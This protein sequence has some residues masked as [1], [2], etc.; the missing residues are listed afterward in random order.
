MI[1]FQRLGHR[2]Q[3][4]ITFL[5]F[6]T[7]LLIRSRRHVA[8]TT[9]SIAFLSVLVE[10]KKRLVAPGL[11]LNFLKVDFVFNIMGYIAKHGVSFASACLTVHKYCSI[12]AIERTHDNFITAVLVNLVIVI[13]L[14]ETLIV[15]VHIAF[16]LGLSQIRPIIKT[17]F[18]RI[19]CH[20]LVQRIYPAFP[21]LRLV[22][23]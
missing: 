15:G 20:R 5:H 7:R 4:R 13:I 21:D 8:D 9:G 17:W 3:D 18:V 14:V 23:V 6:V 12:N 19:G 10:L 2:D 11:C 1:K 22:L 16:Q